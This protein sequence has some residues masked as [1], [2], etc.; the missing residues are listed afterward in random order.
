MLNFN[1]FFTVS[2]VSVGVLLHIQIICCGIESH[3]LPV[4]SIVSFYP[5]E[6]LSCAVLISEP[7][8]GLH[9]IIK[10]IGHASMKINGEKGYAIDSWKSNAR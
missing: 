3:V 7:S 9:F 10:L 5:L 2:I 8:T 6:E 1:I 4:F